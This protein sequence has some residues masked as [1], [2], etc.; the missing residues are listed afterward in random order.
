MPYET[1]GV[2]TPE[3]PPY[4]LLQ[5]RQPYFKLHGS[6]NW[7]TD[8]NSTLLIMGGNKSSEMDQ[9]PLLNWYRSEFCRMTSEPDARLRI[10]GYGFRDMH[11]NE[12]IEVAAKAGTKIFIIDPEGVDVLRRA[13][14]P[15]H[16]L[17]LKDKI[18]FNILGA[19]RRPI[20]ETLSRDTVE[21]TKVMKF[22]P[23]FP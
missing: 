8:S 3:Q 10:I 4:S 15:Q 21:R 18:Q 17:A 1:P 12:M 23:S 16:T 22:F 9:I 19:S 14:N 13:P 11:I 7:R 5:R 20:S 6:S 2:L